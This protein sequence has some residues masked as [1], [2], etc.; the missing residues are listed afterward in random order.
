MN[1]FPLGVPFDALQAL[2]T[3]IMRRM[4]VNNL[5][6]TEQKQYLLRRCHVVVTLREKGS[7]R[8]ERCQSAKKTS[9]R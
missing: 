4:E 9:F 6:H 1:I 8:H 2:V 3:G 5:N 7:T